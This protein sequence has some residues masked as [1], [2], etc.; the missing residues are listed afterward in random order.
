MVASLRFGYVCL[1]HLAM[2]TICY[3]QMC[4]CKLCSFQDSVFS[5]EDF[6]TK[7]NSELLNNLG[8]FINRCEQLLGRF[9]LYLSPDMAL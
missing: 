2:A 8:N 1:H 5:W 6:M 9:L 3:L 7:N 4:K